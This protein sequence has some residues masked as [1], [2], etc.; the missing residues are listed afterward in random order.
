MSLRDELESFLETLEVELPAALEDDTPLLS[1]GQ[2]DSAA[3][4]KLVLWI[5]EKIGAPIDP[6]S[7]DIAT[8]WDSP[9]LI[10]EF[11]ETRTAGSRGQPPAQPPRRASGLVLTRYAPE[12]A[13]A[14]ARLQLGLWSPSVDLNLRY[15]DWKYAQ[16]PYSR[17]PRLY[18]AFDGAELVAMRGFYP[19]RWQAGRPPREEIVLVADDLVVRESHRNRGVVTEVMQWAL[20]DLRRQ[21]V[22]HVLNLSGGQL[23]V[24]GSLAMGWRSA[25]H[26]NP[27][28]RLTAKRAVLAALRSRLTALPLFWRYRSSP[29]FY[30]SAEQQPLARLV[31]PSTCNAKRFGMSV[32]I[33][34]QP[35]AA[36]MAALVARLDYDGRIRHVR[37]ATYLAWRYG[38][39]LNDYRFFYSGSDAL[40][41]YLVVKWAR[42]GS[43]RVEIVDWEAE[44]ERHLGALLEAAI[45]AGS[46]PE[47]VTWGATRSDAVARA[48]AQNRFAPVDRDLAVHGCPCILVRSCDA[49][50][51]LKNW[52][53]NGTPLLD[54]SRWDMRM[55][56]SMAG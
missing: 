34:A 24:L 32:Q 13:D 17:E 4:F 27:L 11:I 3:L 23:T 10:V 14:V 39:P 54:L 52:Q 49:S 56:Y 21:G 15:L 40:R 2:F 5:E 1:T 41:G 18:L 8:A 28:G 20:D 6:S 30:A 36:E 51:A 9:R 55:V 22:Q 26:L 38:N 42:Y 25:G 46:F 43:G 29:L 19:A 45:S 12:H 53:L 44:D 47:L 37:D 48:L 7:L 33:G 35:R 16:N 50:R 31:A